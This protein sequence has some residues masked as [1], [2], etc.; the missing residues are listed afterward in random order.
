MSLVHDLAELP[1]A[2]ELAFRYD[3]HRARRDY[4]AGARDLEVAILGND[5]LELYGPGEIVSGHEFY[6]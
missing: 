2:L 6:D 3:T 4:L 1:A 5:A